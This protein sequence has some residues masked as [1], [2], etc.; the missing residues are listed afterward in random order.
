MRRILAAA[1]LCGF[2]CGPKPPPEVSF[3]YPE[4]LERGGKK[5]EAAAEYVRVCQTIAPRADL[6]AEIARARIFRKLYELRLPELLAARPDWRPRFVAVQSH[7][8]DP[9]GKTLLAASVEA[10]LKV[11]TGPSGTGL[12]AEAAEVLSTVLERRAEGGTFR[13]PDP[14]IERALLY[15]AAAVFEYRRSVLSSNKGRERLIRL[16]R[17]AADE[18]EDLSDQGRPREFARESWRD[19]ADQYEDL[20]IA[21]ERDKELRSLPQDLARLSDFTLERHFREAI[22]WGDRGTVE[23]TSGGD[24]REAERS[25]RTSMRHFVIAE[26]CIAFRTPAQENAL[27]ARMGVYKAWRSLCFEER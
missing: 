2:T 27:S 24:V 12:R 8:T 14:S 11:L 6:Q 16:V 3:E 13:S 19:L 10:Y 7:L 5:L 26:A 23:R 22:Q 18:Y 17:S 21:L 25:Y 4:R 1:I 15:E 9:S 20:S